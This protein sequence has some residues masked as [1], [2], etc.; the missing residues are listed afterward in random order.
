MLSFRLKVFYTVALYL[1]FTKAA[2]ELFISQPAVTKNIK[3]LEQ[4]FDIRLFDRISSKV[5]LTAAG[6]VLLL[7]VKQLIELDK[8]LRFDLNKLNNKYAGELKLGAS[9]TIGQYLLPTILAKFHQLYPDIQIT[10]LNDNTQKI[11]QALQNKEIELGVVEG[12]SLNS[13]LKYTHFVRDEIVAVAHKSQPLFA[14]DE[15]TLDELKSTPLVLREYGSGSLDII[16]DKLNEANIVLKELNIVMHLGSTESIKSYISHANCLGLISIN[17]V[18]R[19]IADG[20]FKIIDI[21][22]I[23]I[24]RTFNFVQLH[25]KLS[26]LSKLFMDFA[27]QSITIGYG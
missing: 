1:N 7:Y 11:E 20:E 21:K 14:K 23:E 16:L 19:E 17:A 2:E 10:L 3:E 27:Q 6:N 18:S 12:M 22:N 8:S 26:G 24:T 9:T 5:T 13:H 4:E 15:I 25:G